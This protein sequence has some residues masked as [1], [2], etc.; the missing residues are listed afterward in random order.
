MA[1]LPKYKITI[2]VVPDRPDMAEEEIREWVDLIVRGIGAVAEI[3]I[4][5]EDGLDA[6]GPSG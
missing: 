3:E 4:E 2:T 1:S 5:E 6:R